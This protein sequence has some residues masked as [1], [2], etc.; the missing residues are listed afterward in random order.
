MLLNKQIQEC[1]ERLLNAFLTNDYKV[2]EEMLHD[3][4]LFVYPNGLPLTKQNVIENYKTGNSA[5]ST[6]SP[7]K[8]II[9]MFG[10]ELQ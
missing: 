7:N 10:N 4:A 6:I 9:N 2:I 8:Q 1:E 5:F 3:D